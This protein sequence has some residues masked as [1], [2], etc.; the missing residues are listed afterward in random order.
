LY[1]SKIIFFPPMDNIVWSPLFPMPL[2]GRFCG[3]VRPAS[4]SFQVSWGRSRDFLEGSFFFFCLFR[5]SPLSFPSDFL[6]P[7]PSRGSFLPSRRHTFP[8]PCKPWS[9]PLFF[10]RLFFGFPG[11][12]KDAVFPKA[13]VSFLFL[14]FSFRTIFFFFLD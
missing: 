6:G 10:R 3:S 8:T 9:C 1:P 11:K 12:D 4:F 13:P 14:F 2:I 5:R 7:L